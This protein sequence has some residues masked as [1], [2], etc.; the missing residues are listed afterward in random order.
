MIVSAVSIPDFDAATS[1]R[2][3]G[4]LTRLFNGI[5][6][7]RPAGFDQAML[8][9]EDSGGALLLV[10]W[11][12]RNDLH[13]FLGSEPGAGLAREFSEIAQ[14][15]DLGFNDYFVTWQTDLAV[16]GDPARATR[17]ED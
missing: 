14:R 17:G 1:E 2:I 11:R 9:R 7:I 16:P 8:L 15:N 3:I 10:Q 5:S 6:R 12:S 4:G 13:A